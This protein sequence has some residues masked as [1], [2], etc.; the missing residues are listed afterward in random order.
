MTAFTINL[1]GLTAKQLLAVQKFETRVESG[2]K[3]SVTVTVNGVKQKIKFNPKV[4]GASTVGFTKAGAPFDTFAAATAPAPV[5]PPAPLGQT[6]TLTDGVDISG[7]LIG[8]A[9][10]VG[11]DGADTF[12]A[13]NAT[14]QTGDVLVGGNGKDVL[15][16][17]LEASNTGVATV[18]GIETIN[19]ASKS[20]ATVA[21][22]ASN[23]TAIGS[24]INLTNGQLGG[25]T[26][27]TVTNLG[28]GA[29]V[30]AD[31]TVT[32]TLSV[33]M[34]AAASQTLTLA[35]NS[36]ATQ[37]VVLTQSGATDVSTIS[38]AGTVD[39][40][41]TDIETQNFSG[42]G[43]AVTYALVS[44]LGTTAN[45]LIGSQSVTLRGSVTAFSGKTVTDST[46]AG[47]TT[48]KI[49]TSGT[50]DLSK[51]S[52]D[53]IELNA[54]TN[55]HTYT[56][57]DKAN[58]K[59]TTAT[60]GTVT[61]D[62]N[63]NTTA[64]A[65]GSAT[66]DL[67]VALVDDITLDTAG[68]KITSLALVNSTANQSFALTAADAAVTVSGT[69]ALELTGTSTA[70]SVDASALSGVLRATAAHNLIKSVTGGSG[71]DLIQVSA[72]TTGATVNGG[73]GNDTITVG[74]AASATINGGAGIDTLSTEGDISK[75]SSSGIEIVSLTG[76]VTAAK[77]SQFSGQN[78]VVD[79]AFA[80]AFGTGTD[81][82]LSTVDLSG[83]VLNAVTSFTL[84]AGGGLDPAKFLAGQGL[85]FVGSATADVVTG[86]ANAD[87]LSGGAGNDLLS[88]GGGND[89]IIGGAGDDIITGG[90]GADVMTGGAGADDFVMSGVPALDVIVDFSLAQGDQI[91][92]FDLSDIAGA[93][94]T[95]TLVP[96]P[97]TDVADAGAVTTAVVTLGGA[98]DLGGVAAG[99]NL[100][101]TNG[102]YANAA[103]LQ[104]DVRLALA[105]AATTASEGFLIAWDDGVNSYIGVVDYDAV[106]ADGD[107][108]SA[109]TVTQ[110]AQLSGVADNTT[111]TT[112]SGAWLA[113]VA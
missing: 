74:S 65:T 82:D 61:F 42:N 6:F 27:F 70:T 17:T 88:G 102:N 41:A 25:T 100:L 13:T 96:L 95:L 3:A 18:I 20:F 60:G 69:K 14:Y 54:A 107:A 75:I 98:F 94:A 50:A 67:A 77:A 37:T 84:N 68:D 12:V 56:L 89:T 32:G 111:L 66:V 106:E 71:N 19:V 11:T 58:V 76:A 85:T 112:A 83:L 53:L 8:S 81:L 26:N 33:T 63:D 51:V 101:L 43:A 103:A 108:L 23:V 105:G 16:L 64:T 79:G 86:T 21:F 10:T 7:V 87:S 78:L 92:G 38:A 48:V 104:V 2:K 15:N 22:N 49:T 36:A 97:T 91:G 59:I 52:V 93:I 34:A 99:T 90:A 29:T 4:D 73:A 109:A 47:T 80:V 30:V 5:T 9:G 113:F 40:T 55:G 57:K 35:A 110:I 39:Y 44:D 46:T 1:D 31:A 62:L 45:N 28:T 72:S 24:T